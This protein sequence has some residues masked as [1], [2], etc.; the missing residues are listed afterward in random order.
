MRACIEAK[1]P[2]RQTAS[3]SLI[4][5]L[6]HKALRFEYGYSYEYFDFMFAHLAIGSDDRAAKLNGKHCT[7]VIR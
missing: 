1:S 3:T 4:L 7:G 6:A 5:W 2:Q